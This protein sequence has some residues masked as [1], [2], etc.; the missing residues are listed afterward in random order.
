ML[1]RY[2]LPRAL[3]AIWATIV[4]CCCVSPRASAE[5]QGLPLADLIRETKVALLRVQE[6]AEARNLPP[7]SSVVLEVN[8]V[9]E[10]EANGSV[11]FLVVELGGGPAS[12][13]TSIFKIKLVPPHPG[14]GT[15]VANIELADRLAEGILASARSLAEAKEGKPSL[16]A[17]EV[18]V[19][20]KFGLTRSVNGGLSIEFPPFELQGGGKV[21]ASEVQI[22]TVTYAIGTPK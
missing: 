10:V 19:A 22:V 12:E 6:K 13:T 9:Q 8:T 7:L 4:A 18:S 21:K 20:L 17:A 16:N 15:D 2:E 3:F 14:E 5:T 1:R 11:K